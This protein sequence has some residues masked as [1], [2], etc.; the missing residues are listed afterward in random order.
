MQLTRRPQ[1]NKVLVLG[2]P[3][4]LLSQ[5]KNRGARNNVA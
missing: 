3:E 4:I 2:S 1:P 5:V